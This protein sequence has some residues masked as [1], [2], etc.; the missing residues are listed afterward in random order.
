MLKILGSLMSKH[1]VKI[2]LLTI[3]VVVLLAAGAGKV[4]LATG[5]ETLISTESSVY[6]SNQQLEEEFG[7]ESIIIVYEAADNQDV[8]TVERL[9]HMKRLETI[10]ITHKEIYS[11]MSPVI[12]LEEISSKQADQYKDGIAGMSDGLNEMGGKLKDFGEQGARKQQKEIESGLANQEGKLGNVQAE[13]EKQA[14]DLNELSNGLNEM[15]KKLVSISDNLSTMNDYSDSLKPGLPVKQET[16][17]YMI[18]DNNGKK[19]EIFNEVVIDDHTMLMIVKFN[20][21]VSDDA[22]S[23]ISKTVKLYLD[24]NQIESTATMVSGKP[25][26]DD[27]IRSSMKESMQKMMMLSILFMVIILLF[28]FN[29]SWRLLPLGIILI[30]VIGTVG[31]MGWIQIPVTMVSM[32]VFPILIGLGIDYAI[33]FQNRYSEEMA[34]GEDDHE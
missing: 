7:G 31:L 21:N 6:K 17:E 27:A 1:P 10:L 5:N 2:M 24:E 14:K 28:T 4:Q 22:K 3:M 32:A 13:K 29:V 30:A 19:R 15:G 9:K 8:L 20:G 33:Q 26:L 25:V 34:E 12:L 18:R 16:L 11:V 23:E